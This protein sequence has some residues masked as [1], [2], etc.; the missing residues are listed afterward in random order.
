MAS[1]DIQLRP[2]PEGA[3]ERYKIR[4]SNGLLAK[5]RKPREWVQ[6]PHKCV[7]LLKRVKLK[8]NRSK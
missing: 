7:V 3:R 2:S 8:K 5:M 4:S 1:F 6:R